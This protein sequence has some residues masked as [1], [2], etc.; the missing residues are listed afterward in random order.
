MKEAVR[1]ELFNGGE[2]RL[3]RLIY[4]LLTNI[5]SRFIFLLR[6][7]S[8]LYERNVTFFPGFISRYLSH[9]Y[10]CFISLNAEIGLGLK[11]PHPNGI[12]IGENVQIGDNCTIYQQ[13]TIGGK[14][15]GDAKVGNYPRIE[16]NIVI[17]AGAK[18]V[19]RIT[20]GEHSVVGANS[21][22]ISDVPPCSVVAGIP[23]RI[24]RSTK[25]S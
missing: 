18:L 8:F 13:V 19:G 6:L 10:G 22:V 7:G 24:I 3:L 23:A 11:V 9:K 2:I 21:V 15:I 4:K 20:V 12:V 14:A 1:V 25:T 16:G 5:P 17:F